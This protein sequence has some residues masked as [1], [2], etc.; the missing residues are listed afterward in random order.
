[1]TSL[2]RVAPSLALYYGL[3]RILTR[4]LVD[5]LA[6]SLIMIVAVALIH[7]CRPWLGRHQLA[8][9]FTTKQCT[10]RTRALISALTAM[11]MSQFPFES[12]RVYICFR[13]NTT[14]DMN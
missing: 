5:L 4:W 14:V 10:Q 1:M 9:V 6:E 12:I 7:H 11:R 8:I 2:V 3:W 13:C